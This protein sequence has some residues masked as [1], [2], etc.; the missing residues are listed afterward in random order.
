VGFARE[1]VH[2]SRGS[3]PCLAL[4]F[5]AAQDA[6]EI[7]PRQDASSLRL[8]PPDM[9]QEAG[10]VAAAPRLA[11]LA[12]Q[13]RSVEVQ[14]TELDLGSLQ[15]GAID[16]QIR[17][18]QVRVT[19]ARIVHAPQEAPELAQEA[20]HGT[21]RKPTGLELDKNLREVDDVVHA[22]RHQLEM[23]AE[24]RGRAR[25]GGN[26]LGGTDA[27]CAQSFREG[28][29]A[30]R[31]ARVAESGSGQPAQEP[32]VT[33][34]P[35]QEALVADGELEQGPAPGEIA[36]LEGRRPGWRET[37]AGQAR[38]LVAANPEQGTAFTL[39]T[40]TAGWLFVRDG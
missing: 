19:E 16:D 18:L 31:P 23:P 34:A 32:A 21:P 12:R 10:Q 29:L 1:L 26:D 20:G 15:G 22:S 17:R 28:E 39:G 7:R 38:G 25:A 33:E 24:E 37:H 2:G 11:E 6:H 3:M 36:L 30:E 35:H 8:P 27:A 4:A 5:V 9:P 40:K 13:L 14:G